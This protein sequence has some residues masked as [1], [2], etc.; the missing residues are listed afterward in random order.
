MGGLL[1]ALN[2]E[3]SGKYYL[4]RETSSTLNSIFKIRFLSCAK[5]L[6]SACYAGYLKG[7]R[8]RLI[9][10]AALGLIE[11]EFPILFYSYF[12]TSI[13]GRLMEGDR[14]MEVQL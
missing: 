13:A 1:A 4:L 8:V 11:A 10:A 5:I 2:F 12:G 7:C 9:E 6:P 14:L 3:A